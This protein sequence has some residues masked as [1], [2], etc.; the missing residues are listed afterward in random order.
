MK[1]AARFSKPSRSFSTVGRN[2]PVYGRFR[3]E[4]Q[5]P[6]ARL[7]SPETPAGAGLFRP[8]SDTL[9][10]VSYLCDFQPAAE[11]SANFGDQPANMLVLPIVQPLPSVCQAQI[12]AYRVQVRIALQQ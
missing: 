5:P 1:W 6:A 3:Q 4:N 7:L 10:N 12:Q 11:Q 2:K 9:R 8:T